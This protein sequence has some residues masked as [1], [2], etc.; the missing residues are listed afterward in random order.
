MVQIY[1]DADFEDVTKDLNKKKKAVAVGDGRKI[2]VD[3]TTPPPT[4]GT[5]AGAVVNSL[6]DKMLRKPEAVP[7]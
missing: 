1:K 7:A 3:E 5:L 4:A 6:T 2:K